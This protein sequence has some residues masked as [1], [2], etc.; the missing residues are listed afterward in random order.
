MWWNNMEK[1]KTKVIMIANYAA[2]Y[3]GN[4]IASLNTLEE[5]LNDLDVTVSYVY[6]KNA[7]F[8]NWGEKGK[9]AENHAIYTV[10]FEPDMLVAKLK[11]MIRS[12]NYN[13]ITII[14]MHF[15]DFKAINAI[16]R[17][18]K[19]KCMF[20]VHEHMRIDFG[21][22]Q[23]G[24]SFILRSKA[25]VKQIFYK[26]ATSTCRMIGVSDA[27]Y[28]DILEIRGKKNPHTYLV[29]NAIST[30]RLDGKRNNIL[31]LDPN[32][33]VVIF[34][35]H[36]ERKGVDLALQAVIKAGNG[37][38]LI[39]LTH[40][41]NDAIEKL[42]DICT[43]W[44]KYVNIFHV[45]EDI[46]SVYNYALCFISPSRSEAF[47]YAVVEAAYCETQVVASAIPGQDSMK[48]I[49]GIKWI[50]SENVDDLAEALVYCYNRRKYCKKEMN[51]VK[52]IQ[53]NYIRTNFDVETWCKEILK[54]YGL[55]I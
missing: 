38:K 39:I 2:F 15:L 20:V 10:D 6:P 32:H 49:P 5:M 4:F 53:K 17:G 34:G 11:Q 44:S 43:E 47:G 23:K 40:N 22:K 26:R 42:N 55:T 8:S 25:F 33:D 24:G 18:L 31:D 9:Y 45:V 41:E 46:P 50:R 29:R 3:S 12:D 51:E 21:I 7:P 19:K 48:C 1:L 35:T 27:V 16:T 37:I 30:D 14:H 54:I 36:F 13:S 52:Q 28:K